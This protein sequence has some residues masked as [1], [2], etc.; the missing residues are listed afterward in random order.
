[1][2]S[3]FKVVLFSTHK[4]GHCEQI[5]TLSPRILYMFLV[6]ENEAKSLIHLI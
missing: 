2:K 5:G 4:T 3:S 6:I 1:M